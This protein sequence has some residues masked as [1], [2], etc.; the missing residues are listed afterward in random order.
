MCLAIVHQ[1]V[2]SRQQRAVNVIVS[3]ETVDETLYMHKNAMYEEV[4][5]KKM[6]FLLNIAYNTDQVQLHRSDDSHDFFFSHVWNGRERKR[7]Q[8]V[9][10]LVSV[11]I[12]ASLL[13]FLCVTPNMLVDVCLMRAGH[14]D[15]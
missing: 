9:R 7:G 12:F 2:C 3:T 15:G 6:E 5:T 11:A 1:L 13:F 8:T 4:Q 14:A 10:G